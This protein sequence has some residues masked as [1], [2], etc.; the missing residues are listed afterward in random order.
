[1]PG[2]I[3]LIVAEVAALDEKAYVA[4]S[5]TAAVV[6]TARDKTFLGILLITTMRTFHGLANGTLAE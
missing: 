1:M 6:K 3:P 4:E 2:R 5:A